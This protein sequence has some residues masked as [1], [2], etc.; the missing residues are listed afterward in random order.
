MWFWLG[1]AGVEPQRAA[2]AQ[3]RVGAVGP[4]GAPG[5]VGPAGPPGAPGP[6]GP[7]ARK[8]DVYVAAHT[9]RVA[10]A[11]RSD[12][13]VACDDP[14]DLLLSGSCNL[15]GGVGATVAEAYGTGLDDE[16]LLAAWHCGVEAPEWAVGTASVTASAACLAID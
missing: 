6:R 1:C 16:A 5:P 3:S 4:P 11:G 13:T 14:R 10:F 7:A 2:P 15:T 12:V 9:V 8:R